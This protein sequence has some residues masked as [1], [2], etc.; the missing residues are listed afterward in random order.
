[1]GHERQALNP[2]R[3]LLPNIRKNR[4]VV[5]VTRP[6]PVDLPA[7]PAVVLRLR[8]NQAV[9]CVHNPS[10]PHDDNPYTADTAEILVGRLEI[11]RREIIHK[12][13]GMANEL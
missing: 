1:M 11:D 9:E 12:L 2:G 8:M 5:R 6:Q 13:A 10:A 7:E 4:C 3:N